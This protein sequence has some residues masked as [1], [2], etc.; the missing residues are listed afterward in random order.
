VNPIY[1][2]YLATTPVDPRVAAAMV[3]CLTQ[4]G[5]FGNPASRSH[6][7][8]WQAEAAVEV[9]R[10][11]VAALIGADPR[12]IIWTSGATEADNMALF[13]LLG[14]W[15]APGGH[16]VTSSIE[17]KAVLDCAQALRKVKVAVT[18]V[19][20]GTDGLVEPAA[21]AAA[22][23][24]DTR[25]VSIM[26]VNNELGTINDVAAIGAICRDAGVLFHTDAAQSCGKVP[27]S[28]DAIRADL[29]SLSA[30]KLY[31][32]KGVGALWVRAPARRQ[33]CP[34]LYGGGHERGLRPGTLATHQIVGLGLAAEI[35]A[36]EQAQEAERLRTLRERLWASLAGLDGLVLNGHRH[37]RLPGALNVSVAGV[38]GESLLLALSELATSTG[39]ACTSATLE[40]SYVLRAI[41]VPDA[42]AYSSLRLSLGRYT[43]NDDVDRASEILV[44]T[45]RR[46]R[47]TPG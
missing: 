21:V 33:L 27:V 42:L 18:L 45:I 15:T 43:S 22:L 23:R 34:L 14:P 29:L 47:A 41:G 35:A 36:A 3:T 17:H 20:P 11:Q 19:A 12:D 46:L 9:A 37:K 30:H 10:G 16:L 32:P 2:D 44:R 39:S 4:D 7:Y 5:L 8:G 26:H 40:P 13:G 38:D 28:V 1:L 25:L 6:V 24:P 31:G